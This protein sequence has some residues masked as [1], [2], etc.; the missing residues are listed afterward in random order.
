MLSFIYFVLFVEWKYDYFL[1]KT[2][3]RIFVEPTN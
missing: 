3:T 1:I 2:N